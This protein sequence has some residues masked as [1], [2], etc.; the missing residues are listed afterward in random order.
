[1]GEIVKKK[2]TDLEWID[3]EENLQM[4]WR[5][6]KPDHFSVCR[7]QFWALSCFIQFM[8]EQIAAAASNASSWIFF[9]RNASDFDLRCCH[10]FNSLWS[11]KVERF[12]LTLHGLWFPLILH[13]LLLEVAF[14]HNAERFALIVI[15]TDIALAAHHRDADKLL[16]DCALSH[17][18][19]LCTGQV[20][21]I[22]K[23]RS[24]VAIFL[25]K[26]CAWANFYTKSVELN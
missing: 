3:L 8:E 22:R 12:S 7:P 10:S 11:H 1:M 17:I 23:I 26:K 9:S 16:L 20:G 21:T 19:Q 4:L 5:K 25:A 18:E 14:V 15:C 13:Q 24:F 2:K 6:R